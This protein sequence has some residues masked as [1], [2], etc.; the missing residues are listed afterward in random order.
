RIQ[1]IQETHNLESTSQSN[2]IKTLHTQL[3]EAEALLS[4][5]QDAD[6][7]AEQA[8]TKN[9]AEIERLQSEVERTKL[10]AK[11][12]EEKR[13]KAISL[14]KTV[15]QKLVKAEKE[16][17]DALKELGSSRER[18]YA[19][20]DHVQVER[21]RLQ[22][23]LSAVNV[24]REKAISG[25][26]AQFDK[27]IINIRERH[28]KD[29]LAQREN[30]ETENI[31]IKNTHLAELSLSLSRIS[32][33]ETSLNNVT[34]EKN[35]LFDHLQLRQ[36]ELES[37]QSHLES[38]QSQN[39][40]LQYQL[41]ET[42]DRYSLLKEDLGEAHRELENRS[43]G[44]VT[45]AGEVAR[46]LSATETKYDSKLSDLKNHI[47]IL[48]KE[49]NDGEAEWSQKLRDK[50]KEVE[51]LKRALGLAT[52]T[53]QHDEGIVVEL[54]AEISRLADESH[55]LQRQVNDLRLTNSKVED[56][57]RLGKAQE[58]ELNT[59]VSALER[60]MEDNKQREA[61]LRLANKTLREELRKV[62]SSAALLERQRNPGV[63]Y[64]TSRTNDSTTGAQTSSPMPLSDPT[65]RAGSPISSPTIQST[66]EEEVNLEYLRNV[67]LQFLEHKE[68]RPNLVKVLSI[69]LRF[70]P[71]ETRRLIA[72]V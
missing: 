55:R 43:R 18:E 14:L 17:D 31:L 51:D 61:Q 62:Q 19:D 41:R 69:I 67:I 32:T 40:E 24:E 25:L 64:W 22:S 47:S 16:K 71:H 36:G 10:L 63:G 3:K 37:A 66:S 60:Q 15:R 34:K 12:E 6:A 45:T 26:K 44:P 13:V 29:I 11:E 23:E 35:V 49:R 58:L 42:D 56:I 8:T 28:E 9:K 72:K 46:L 5:V 21:T 20:R 33:L 2:Q 27:D 59:K 1:E 52:R 53:R 38:L 4:A 57:E 7:Q 54:K 65:S 39:T 70:T 48:V 30:Y 68:M 50:G